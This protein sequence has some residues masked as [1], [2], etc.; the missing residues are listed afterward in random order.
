[1]KEKAPQILNSE[2]LVAKINRDK[3]NRD[4]VEK[5]KAEFLFRQR[6][7]N[8][9]IIDWYGGVGSETVVFDACAGPEGS[10]LAVSRRGG[11]WFGNEISTKTASHLR[12]TGANTIIGTADKLPLQQKSVDLVLYVFA[13][14]NI[15]NTEGALSEAQRVLRLNGDI[16]ISDPGQTMW[17][18]DL[19][20][21]EAAQQD[22][23]SDEI[24]NLLQKANRFKVE[25]PEYF[26]S[27]PDRKNLEHTIGSLAKLYGL[28]LQQTAQIVG[29]LKSADDIKKLRRDFHEALEGR[30]WAYIFETADKI[31][32]SFKRLGVISASQHHG[33][34]NWNI[35]N[36]VNLPLPKSS[37]E[38]ADEVVALRNN[39][40]KLSS[41]IIQRGLKI[42]KNIISPVVLLE[43]RE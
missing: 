16:L 10:Y 18:T 17:A 20:L 21:Y 30:Y 31:G 8:E 2:S 6:I 11:K 12:A 42:N 27:Y 7:I 23:L 19:Y 40:H 28:N 37:Q 3:I 34:E 36:V 25:I 14:N 5:Y 32:L 29:S 9:R 43:K 4:D 41:Q 24:K 35:G 26:K 33:E 15:E 39:T 13:L 38:L 1:M 22:L